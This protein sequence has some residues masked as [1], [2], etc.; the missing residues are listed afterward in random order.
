M[1]SIFRLKK[2]T[3]QQ[4]QTNNK[5]KTLIYFSFDTVVGTVIG[6]FF[7]ILNLLQAHL[8]YYVAQLTLG[9]V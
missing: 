5:K 1:H 4:Q 3:E 9:Q 7:V 2:K 6:H 8:C